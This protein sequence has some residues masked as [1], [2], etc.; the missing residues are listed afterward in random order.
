MNSIIAYPEKL[1][2]ELYPRIKTSVETGRWL[3]GE[4]MSDQKKE[5]AVQLVL[6]YQNI[7]NKQPEHF[8]IDQKGEIFMEKKSVLREQF[9]SKKFDEESQKGKN[10]IYQI[11]L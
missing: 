6:A 8:T 7:R 1:S 10:D 3:D 2:P 11:D 9:S 5:E 4:K